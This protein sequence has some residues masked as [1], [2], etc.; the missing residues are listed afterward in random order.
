MYRILSPTAILGYGFPKPS[1]AKAMELD[2]DL[3]AVDAGSMDAGPYY[4]GSD[5]QYVGK[6]AL[7]RDLQIIVK[8]ALDQ[9]CPLVIGSAGFSGASPQIEEVISIVK[10]AIEH[11]N[12][13]EVKVAIIR[14]DIS[15]ELL[16]PFMDTLTPLGKMPE[17]DTSLVTTSAS[18]ANSPER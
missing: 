10:N 8:G 11:E 4:L 6:T 1:F 17:L 13:K 14:S 9:Q 18:P 7:E 12:A 16:S 2:I 15:F 3:I 5:K